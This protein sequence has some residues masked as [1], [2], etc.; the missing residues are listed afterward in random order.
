MAITCLSYV[1]FYTFPV[2]IGSGF[3]KENL[4]DPDFDEEKELR[5]SKIWVFFS[6]LS[7]LL[8]YSLVPLFK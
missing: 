6:L 2:M 4:E 8:S 3:I 7:E 1:L 5:T